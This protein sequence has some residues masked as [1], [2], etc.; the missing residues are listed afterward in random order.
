MARVPPAGD[1]L[2]FQ[3]NHALLNPHFESYK[4]AQPP[5]P[6]TSH[7][8]P[9]PFRLPALPDHARLSYNEV[10]ARARHNHLAAG[11][12]RDLV[13][14]DGEG[15]LT[16]LT[17]DPKTAVPTFHPLLRLPI[18]STSSP[19]SSTTSPSSTVA[20]YPTALAVA[21]SLW[22]VSDG[23]GRLS[24]VRVDT[25]SSP[26]WASTIHASFELR[27]G[28]DAPT[29]FRLHAVEQL[30]DAEAVV[31]LSVVTKTA[32]PSPATSGAPSALP[33]PSSM[34]ATTRHT[35][36]S[37]TQFVYLSARIALA[38]V[39]EPAAPRQ[40]AVSWRLTSHDLP[41]FVVYDRERGAFVIG[42][43]SKLV[44]AQAD[45]SAKGTRAGAEQVN[46]EEGADDEDVLMTPARAASAAASA[47][48]PAA[49]R[50]PPF[51]WTQDKDSVTVAFPVPS[52]TPTSSIRLTFS[53]LYLTLHV[54]SSSAFAA[55]STGLPGG[56]GL[57]RVSHKRLW[58]DIDPHTSVWTFD[59]E[60]EGRDSSYG[61]LTLHLEKAHAGTRW[62]DV[63]A[64]SP[65]RDG[66]EAAAAVA[67]GA[68]RI[69]ELDPELEYEGVPESLD[70]SELAA[71]TEQMEQWA[72][73]LV[74]HGIG[75][76]D[77]GLGSGIPTSL[78]GE[79]VDVE[80]D[81]ECGRPFVVTWIEGATGDEQRRPR[82]VH[83]HAAVPYELLSTPF[84]LA[85][86]TSS[87]TSSLASFDGITVKH[88]VDG[89]LFTPPPA[90]TAAYE[91]SHASTFPALAFVLA[92]KRDTRFVHHLLPS[93]L[94]SSSSG[95]VL[96]FDAPALP[97]SGGPS[98]PT[99]DGANCFVYL[100]PPA[101]TAGARARTGAQMVLRVGGPGAG[102]LIGVAAIELE[103]GERAVV[104]LCEREVVVIR[105]L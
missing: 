38:P 90:S 30:S 56:V 1:R 37:T 46:E 18:D 57:P 88:D 6:P 22:A 61:L 39:A 68:A 5:H 101:P 102:A 4:L 75:H 63:F 3:A 26:S 43:G 60:A 29:P 67:A 19:S 54:S 52:D 55:S 53:R 31:L 23:R 89:L 28:A 66:D 2:S 50:P 71:I 7:P 20:E 48:G 83:P 27:E 49:P 92:T 24:L 40:L 65:A 76:S 94:S 95:A 32:A 9:A 86:G 69:E 81:A 59:R 96:A 91:W 10:A 12:A 17:V 8:L 14:V 93:S 82:L 42:A 36:S 99:R 73:G 34:A 84:P 100:S 44:H 105:V 87:S 13:F 45:D 47:S 15:Q 16:A 74:R 62:S 72:Q 103:G 104:A 98:A 33:T 41:S 70:P 80:V 25:A 85:L 21:P 79:E 77:E 97:T 64:S 11:H 78:T 51:S 58:A 35:I